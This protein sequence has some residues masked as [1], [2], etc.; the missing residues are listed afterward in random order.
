MP[1]NERNRGRRETSPQKKEWETLQKKHEKGEILSRKER[2]VVGKMIGEARKKGEE[3]TVEI[4][5][6]ILQE[7][8]GR[9]R[10]EEQPKDVGTTW[11]HR[12]NPNLHTS[13][14]VKQA[15]RHKRYREKGEKEKKQEQAVEV[16]LNRLKEILG[17]QNEEK[18]EKD[19]TTL[20]ELL[21]RRYVIRK[22]NIPESYWENYRA[23]LRDEGHGEVTITEEMKKEETERIRV[24][25]R[26]TLDN[27]FD[28]LISQ[29][30]LYPMWVK[31]W[32]MTGVASLGR[33]DKER[34][35]FTRRDSE[36]VAPFP[37]INR[38]ALAYITDLI[39]RKVRRE[40]IE[41]ATERVSDEEFIAMVN[42]MDFG[43]YYAFALE[44]TSVSNE[45]LFETTEGQWV[46]YPQGSDH[47]PL[48]ESIQGHGT[49]WCT[50]GEETAKKQLEMGDFH[51]YYSNDLIGEPTIPRVAIRMQQGSIAEVRGVAPDQNFDPYITPTVEEKL[52]EFPDGEQYKQRTEDMTYLT[53]IDRRKEEGEE[54][55]KEDLR[56][57]Y[58]IDRKIESPGYQQDPRIQEIVG[59]RDIKQDLVHILNCREDQISLTED[60][61]LSGDIVYHF[62]DLD[63]RDLTEAKGLQLPREVGGSL[64]LSGLKEAKGLQLP[65]KVGGHLFLNGLKEAKGLQLPKEVGGSLGLSGLKEAKGLQLPREMR[66]SLDLSGLKEAKGLQLPREVGGDLNLRG[67]TTAE[68][69]QLPR[70]VGGDLNLRGLTTA[71]G[72]QLP[73]KVGGY[74]YLRDLTTAEKERIQKEYPHIHISIGRMRRRRR[75]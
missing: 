17:Q 31:Y 5:Q 27:W 70:E 18:R 41:N 71:E 75:I 15:T 30:A 64:G 53:D 66:G 10:Q 74:L 34:R 36:T 63:L 13:Y 32:A 7:Q 1:F 48:V 37:Y 62:G 56:F 24:E 54:L 55:T 42:T 68:G 14:E 35:Q 61:A 22:E 9:K 20:R 11:T 44:H 40:V 49:G 50:A 45:T 16:Y 6:Q 72:L 60:E 33:Y 43:K 39:A 73:R 51:V 4:L 23:R 12:S 69:L 2:G 3:E 46:T 21:H 28:Y 38:E 19:L 57:L 26:G 52:Q 67:L 58:E 29:D 8:A 47:M 65:R 25:Q 59:D